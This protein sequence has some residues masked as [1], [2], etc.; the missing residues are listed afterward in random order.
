[1]KLSLCMMNKDVAR[2]I[3][4]TKNIINKLMGVRQNGNSTHRSERQL[5]KSEEESIPNSDFTQPSNDST[6]EVGGR[7][8][9]DPVR[10]GDWERNGIA[11]DF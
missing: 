6:A 5:T 9:L 1:M 2:Q 7:E 8:G 3:Y 4:F 10:Y 11:V